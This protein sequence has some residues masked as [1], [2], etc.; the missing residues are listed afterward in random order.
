M[1][2]FKKN[3]LTEPTIS[4]IRIDVILGKLHARRSGVNKIEGTKRFPI[5]T[6]RTVLE[7]FVE[8]G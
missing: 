8:A 7:A 4:V 1:Q 2:N 5:S 6:E 3:C